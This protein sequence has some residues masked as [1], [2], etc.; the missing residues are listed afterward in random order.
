MCTS[1]SVEY[2]DE[3]LTP[4]NFIMDTLTEQW[5]E[6]FHSYKNITLHNIMIY[7]DSVHINFY[8]IISLLVM[9]MII[10]ILRSVEII[11]TFSIPSLLQERKRDKSTNTEEPEQQAL[12]HL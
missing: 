10:H 11:P 8:V 12:R 2:E 1:S 3:S 9:F 6:T 4:P 5:N 7:T